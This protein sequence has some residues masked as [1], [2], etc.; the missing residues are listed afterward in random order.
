MSQHWY[1]D[2]NP[3]QEES[4]RTTELEIASLRRNISA[5]KRIWREVNH[6]YI[7]TKSVATATLNHLDYQYE[8]VKNAVDELKREVRRIEQFLE[9]R[10]SNPTP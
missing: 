1:S 8:H 5:M 2:N 4:L 9:E 10:A 7:S 6:E 3:D